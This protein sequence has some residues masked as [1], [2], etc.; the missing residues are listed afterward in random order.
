MKTV[1]LPQKKS[2]QTIKSRRSLVT[3]VAVATFTI[4]SLLFAGMQIERSRYEKPLP[5]NQ[6][7]LAALD[8]ISK[9]L[10]GEAVDTASLIKACRDNATKY[11]VVVAQ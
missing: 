4:G 9:A 5:A 8:G 6:A 3:G 11:E 2:T 10:Q 7:C 1:E